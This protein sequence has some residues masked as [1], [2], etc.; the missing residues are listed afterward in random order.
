MSSVITHI[1]AVLVGLG[2]GFLAS[3][4][5]KLRAEVKGIIV[6]VKADLKII[7]DLVKSK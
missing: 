7:L 5:T 6:E 1:V 2:S 4:F 3:E